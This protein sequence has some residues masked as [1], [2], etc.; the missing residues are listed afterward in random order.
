MSSL[1][2]WG[3]RPSTEEGWCQTCMLGGRLMSRSRRQRDGKF[4]KK[5]TSHPDSSFLFYLLLPSFTLPAEVESIEKHMWSFFHISSHH[6]LFLPSYSISATSQALSR[7]CSCCQS[8]VFL[9]P[10]KQWHFESMGRCE[11]AADVGV[12]ILRSTAIENI[13][14]MLFHTNKCD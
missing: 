9:S 5:T 7:V 11:I 10:S 6:C 3:P 14:I 8:F 4:S 12:K 13:G 2:Q 1:P